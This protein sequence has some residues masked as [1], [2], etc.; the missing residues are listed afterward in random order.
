MSDRIFGGLGLLLSLLFIYAATGVELPFIMD[1]VGPRTWP[2]VIGGLGAIGCVA[3]LARPDADPIW[4]PLR[5]LAE[6]GL[7]A[8][9]MFAYAAFLADL[10]FVLATAVASAVLV[11]RL[12]GKLVESVL[13][14]VAISVGIYVVFHLAFGLSL[15]RG[16]WGF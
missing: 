10:G 1:P 2:M 16:P 12:G 8:V 6:I 11:Q 14:G 4:P 15:A 3:I 13:A 5:K 7:A 9:V